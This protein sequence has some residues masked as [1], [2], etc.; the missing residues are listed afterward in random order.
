[1]SRVSSV[2]SIWLQ[3]G[4]L[5]YR[6]S[7]PGGRS[8]KILRLASVSRSALE[9]TQT[10]VQWVPW[11]LSSGLK[12]GRSVTLT[13]HS[14]LVP[15]SRMS[16]SYTSSPL[17]RHK[18]CTGTVLALAVSAFYGKAFRIIF[19]KLFICSLYVVISDTKKNAIIHLYEFR[20]CICIPS[21]RISRAGSFVSLYWN[22]VT[23]ELHI[24][25][26]LNIRLSC[27]WRGLERYHGNVNRNV[28]KGFNL[29][30]LFCCMAIVWSFMLKLMNYLRCIIICIF[31]LNI[32]WS[33]IFMNVECVAT[34][35]AEISLIQK[36]Y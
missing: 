27:T 36:Y 6:G 8:E 21:V 19:I 4:W 11:F 14:H 12:R 16:R 3:T 18:M 15:R 22:A 26:L 24:S 17:N 25:T 13:T 10:P 20:V 23:T 30:F 33:I 29:L 34:N 9:P 32:L 31:K 5:G 28:L 1:M 2:S 7:I 35:E